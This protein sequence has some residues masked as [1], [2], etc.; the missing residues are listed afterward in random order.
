M[1]RFF[2][3][4]LLCVV[5]LLFV[6][7]NVVSAQ[8][9]KIGVYD[10]ARILKESKTIEGYSKELSKGI[11]AKKPV[12]VQKGEA[13]RQLA[14]K[15]KNEGPSLSQE[16]RTALA[17]KVVND[18]KELKRMRED[19]DTEVR[20]V[21]AQLRQK[22]VADINQAVKQLGDKENYTIIF[23]KTNAGVAY[24]KETVDITGKILGIMK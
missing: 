19:V 9:L 12:L 14:E 20:K 16:Q 22:V 24:L 3:V 5:F 15:L 8:A 7:A 21:Q 10:S 18:D 11:E 1:K 13:L 2:D 17:E 23:E 4:G 6:G